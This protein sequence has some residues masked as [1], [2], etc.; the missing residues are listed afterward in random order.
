[1]ADH[2][3]LETVTQVLPFQSQLSTFQSA[4]PHPPISTLS[5]IT[6]SFPISSS[7]PISS[8]ISPSI[9]SP[10]FPFDSIPIPT[11][12]SSILRP[13][14]LPQDLFQDFLQETISD[15]TPD[16]F[17]FIPQNLVHSSDDY[18]LTKKRSSA[19]MSRWI[20]AI[21]MFYFM[22]LHVLHFNIRQA[23]FDAC[24]GD[25]SKWIC[26]PY[27]AATGAHPILLNDIAEASYPLWPPDLILSTPNL[28][29][30]RAIILQ[31]H[32]GQ[33]SQLKS[34]V[35]A[36]I[37]QAAITFK[38]QYK[39]AISDCNFKPG[40]LVLIR[41]T[42]MEIA[43]NR[44]MR[45]R[46]LGPLIVIARDKEGAYIISELNDSVFDR[47]I[48]A[49]RVIPRFARTKISLSPLVKLLDV[50]QQRFQEHTDSEDSDPEDDN[51]CDSSDPLPDDWGQS[52]LK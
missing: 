47:S 45:A 20:L 48:A 2:R 1:M 23:I 31:K 27:F 8:V 24:D 40:D 14:G 33:L 49:F 3:T 15:S 12:S 29:S 32:R 18:V 35:Y 10:L 43:L 50:S 19:S 30:R 21:L 41:N 7:T 39:L 6:N 36:A 46:Y 5:F 13:Q 42:T 26:S 51:T 52:L 9:T 16:Q 22:L 4:S 25:E 38:E 28:M 11:L 44:K 37:I 34:K 17:T